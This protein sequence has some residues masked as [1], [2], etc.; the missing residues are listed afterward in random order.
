MTWSVWRVA[1]IITSIF[2]ILG[3]FTLYQVVFDWLKTILRERK[4]D[5]KDET[6]RSWFGVI[7][8]LIFIFSMQS[9]LVG[10]KFSWEFMNFII[11]AL[12]FCAYFLNIRIPIYLFLPIVLV[13]MLFNGS[14]GYW[15]SWCHAI[16]LI[17]TYWA[18]NFIKR[19]PAHADSF[20]S[21]MG[22]GIVSGAIMWFFVA[23]KFHLSP[24]VYIQEWGYLIIFEVLLYSYVRMLVR[25]S[26]LKGH[27]LDFANHDA[28]TKSKNYAAYNSDI[29]ILFN[30]SLENNLDLS[31]MMFDI[32]HFKQ[33]NDSYGHLAGDQ[34]LKETSAAVQTVINENDS[35]VKLYRTGGEEFNVVFPGYDLNSTKPL[36]TEIFDTLNNMSIENDDKKI[37]I[38]VSIGVSSLHNKD[39]STDEFY[40]RVDKNLYHSKENG[41][42]QITAV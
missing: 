28:L 42:H 4:V 14:F 22:I 32:D 27:L 41:R 10:E 21:Y 9:T 18:F 13:Y 15:E 6:L 17:L 36:V 33:V 26:K 12:I 2:F 19:L 34:V 1:P 5:F 16:S 11:I 30:H 38:T 29:K 7:Y 40:K 3:V 8:M 23:V 20:I 39:Q 25:E 37:R 35:N 24:I 31:M